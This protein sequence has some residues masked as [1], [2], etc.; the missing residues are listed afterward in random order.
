MVSNT[1][2]RR[3]HRPRIA[4]AGFALAVLIVVAGCGDDDDAAPEPTEDTTTT[5]AA[6]A[7]SSTGA[8]GTATTD[9]GDLP[10]E[11][12]EIHPYEGDRL[13]VAGVAADDT[14]NVR[15]AP[16]TGADVLFEL[17][18]LA[19]DVEA[20]G[21]NRS[22]EGGGVW[23][24][25]TD[26]DRRGWANVAFLAYLGAT[27]DVTSE[28]GMPPAAETMVE[29]GQQVATLRAGDAPDPDVTVVAGPTV[30]DLGEITV[31]VVGLADDAQTGERLAVFAEPLPDGETFRTRT[32]EATTLCARGVTDDGLCV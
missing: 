2:T 4:G 17:E 11:P 16:G 14:L 23:A 13:A 27:R 22:I 25:V 7:T 32:V 15:T 21:H 20:T 30:G 1:R 26:G 10:G 29:I 8:G 12:I 24:E 3:A 9:P 18:P 5:T 31:D 6:G 28:I 19:T